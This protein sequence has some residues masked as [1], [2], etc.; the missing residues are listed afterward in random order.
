MAKDKLNKKTEKKGFVFKLL[1][2]AVIVMVVYVIY[3][4]FFQ[5]MEISQKESEIL[6]L[7][8]QLELAKS[9]NDEYNSL[10]NLANSDDYIRRIA[11]E[12]YG[13]AYKDETRIYIISKN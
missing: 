4:F 9:K 7:E 13:Y 11:I 12:E 8:Q 3:V 6:L 1:T 5:Q 2:F 10:L